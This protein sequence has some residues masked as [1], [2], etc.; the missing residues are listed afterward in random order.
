MDQLL[1]SWQAGASGN[2]I[3]YGGNN[4]KQK[5]LYFQRT[6]KT[7]GVFTLESRDQLEVC[8]GSSQALRFPTQCKYFR[9]LIFLTLPGGLY[10]GN[11]KPK[12]LHHQGHENLCKWR[13]S[14]IQRVMVNSGETITPALIQLSECHQP[15]FTFM[16]KSED[17]SN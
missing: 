11:T 9:Y 15:L 5:D 12:V 16:K 2:I 17:W 13:G 8:I 14:T 3:S 7:Q 4:T 10:L 1:V 6:R